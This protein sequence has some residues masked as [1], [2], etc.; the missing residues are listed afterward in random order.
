M[1]TPISH[2]QIKQ[3]RQLIKIA[4]KG[5]IRQAAE[6]LAITQPALSRS[7]RAIEQNLQVKLMDRGPR[8]IELTP[9]GETLV[10]YG[11]II[12]ANL[13][14]AAE[15]LEE[16][17]GNKEGCVNIGTGPFEGF[18]VLHL[19]IERFLETRPKTEISVVEGD[20]DDLSANLKNGE[21]DIMFGPTQFDGDTP[22]LKSE[23][24]TKI[25]PVLV[26]R[27][28]HPFANLDQISFKDL[29]ETDWILPPK[30]ARART[31]L[32]N[33]F[34]RHGFVPPKGL[35]EMKPGL[36]MLAL[37]QRRNLVALLSRHLIA[38][39]VDEGSVKILPVDN[40]EFT[41]PMQLTTREFGQL[42]PACRDM[43]S[44]IKAV[45]QEVGD[46]R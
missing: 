3:L 15:E 17:K 46:I 7:I 31:R 11:K 45:C 6:A 27:A 19:A 13:R 28:E 4:E 8:G 44:A 2:L 43:I 23:I 21:I 33:I 30:S 42:S 20:F 9:H 26:V 5:S 35:I 12:E 10:N 34:I 22:G 25:H 37:L 36:A 38:R 39:E 41:L 40:T 18:T 16:L 24:L 32:H 14:F 1:N 29:S